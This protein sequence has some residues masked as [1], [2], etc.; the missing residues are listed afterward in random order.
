MVYQMFFFTFYR[1]QLDEFRVKFEHRQGFGQFV[2]G[3]ICKS[4]TFT[5]SLYI[6]LNGFYIPVVELTARVVGAMK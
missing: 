2:F 6:E 1:T 4:F 5:Y 3:I